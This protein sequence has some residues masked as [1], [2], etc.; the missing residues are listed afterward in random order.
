MEKRKSSSKASSS[1]TRGVALGGRSGA[2]NDGLFE[3]DIEN[4]DMIEDRKKY[5]WKR[6]SFMGLV[7][8]VIILLVM[9]YFGRPQGKRHLKH[10]YM[11]EA[12]GLVLPAAAIPMNVSPTVITN[13]NNNANN[14][15]NANSNNN[16]NK[17]LVVSNSHEISKGGVDAIMSFNDNVNKKATAQKLIDDIRALKKRG[18]VIETSEEAQ[19]LITKLQP[20][21]RE[22]LVETYGPEPYHVEMLL[23]FPESMPDYSVA[24]KDGRI[25]VELAPIA[26][27][28]YCVYFFLSNVVDK[29][30]V[31]VF[32][33]LDV[34][35][36][37]LANQWYICVFW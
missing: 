21:L 1:P 32:A 12:T 8:V 19:A 10:D 14:N 25:V 4:P 26:L 11:M 13:A 18:V 3:F 9:G 22:V 30:Q 23:E 20:L 16:N 7:F 36:M 28:P 5:S 29:W 27:V 35:I 33:R 17:Q 37:K 24:G 6:F 31:C 2:S 34:A 15:N